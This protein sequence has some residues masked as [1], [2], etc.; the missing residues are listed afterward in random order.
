MLTPGKFRELNHPDW[1]CDNQA[2]SE[3]FGWHP[4]VQF[5]E[6]LRRTIA[7]ISG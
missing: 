3:A 2:F 1:V 5:Q 7:H 4:K 6:G